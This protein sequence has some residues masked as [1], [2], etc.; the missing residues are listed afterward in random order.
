MNEFDAV[1]LGQHPRNHHLVVVFAAE[2][3]GSGDGGHPGKLI[4]SGNFRNAFKKR[5]C[6]IPTD[7]YY[8][9][10]KA[11]KAKQPYYIHKADQ[12]PFA[13]AGLW[14]SWHTGQED[15]V[16]SFTVITTEANEAMATVH[17]RMP[18]IVS[19]DDFEMWL[20]PEFEG[21]APLQSLLR[22]YESDDL[23]LVPVSTIVNS[24]RNDDPEC[25]RAVA[26]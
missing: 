6:L 9:W 24:P 1:I 10:K 12:T 4:F 13:M 26:K 16:E 15:A 23:T 11:G 3:M 2:E 17:D 8:E 7:G 14:E 25:I 5:R 21:Q 18:V 19:P 20:D 22:P